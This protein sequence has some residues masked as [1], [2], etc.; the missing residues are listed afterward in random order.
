MSKNLSENR[1]FLTL[2]LES[3]NLQARALLDSATKKQIVVLSEIISNFMRIS[4]KDKR[5]KTTERNNFAIKDRSID[6]MLNAKRSPFNRIASRNVS[7]ATKARLIRRHRKLILRFLIRVK[8]QL[9][10]LLASQ[11]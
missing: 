9:L 2:L 3:T 5:T 4:G 10:G 8:T 1:A 7:T 11:E 6:A